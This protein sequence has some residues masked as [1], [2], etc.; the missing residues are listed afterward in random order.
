[1]QRKEILTELSSSGLVLRFRRRVSNT[2]LF[3]G[4]DSAS[5]DC[6]VK[7]TARP[8]RLRVSAKGK[9]LDACA[10]ARGCGGGWWGDSKILRSTRSARR[11]NLILSPSHGSGM[12]LRTSQSGKFSVQ[13]GRAVGRNQR[14]YFNNLT[15]GRQHPS[16]AAV[17]TFSAVTAFLCAQPRLLGSRVCSRLR[18]AESLRQNRVYV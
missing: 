9:I 3:L 4:F 12:T 10:C 2:M 1:M 14:R 17:L 5:K 7:V 15:R 8:A 16:L 18:N 13:T 6:E 11:V